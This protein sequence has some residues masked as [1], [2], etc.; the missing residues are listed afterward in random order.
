MTV[1]AKSRPVVTFKTL[2]QHYQQVLKS[3]DLVPHR[4]PPPPT[5]KALH[6][7]RVALLGLIIVPILVSVTTACAKWTGASVVRG[8]GCSSLFYYNVL[9]VFGESCASLR[10]V[11]RC[12]AWFPA[13]IQTFVDAYLL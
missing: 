2:I 9:F 10:Y 5:G 1:T 8:I 11:Q 7:I 6:R 3:L 12:A 4:E 13:E